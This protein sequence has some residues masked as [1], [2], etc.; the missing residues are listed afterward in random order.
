MKN[1][2]LAQAQAKLLKKIKNSDSGQIS[3]I[4]PRDKDLIK[5]AQSLAKQGIVRLYPMTITNDKPNWDFCYCD[6]KVK[7]NL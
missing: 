1:P 5:A 3:L 7:K 2:T 6:L 4:E